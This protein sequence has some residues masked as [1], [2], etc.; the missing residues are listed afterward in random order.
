MDEMTLKFLKSHKRM[1][2]QNFNDLSQQYNMIMNKAGEVKQ[3]YDT[4]LA[5][6]TALKKLLEDVG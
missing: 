5:E 1:L 3:K 6:L 4:T 2:Q